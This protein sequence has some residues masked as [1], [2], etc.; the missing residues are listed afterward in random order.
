MIRPREDGEELD[1]AEDVEVDR[2]LV[3]LDGSSASEAILWPAARLAR[4]W[5]ATVTVL[6]IMPYPDEIASAY[7]PHTVQMNLAAL[8]GGKR[9]ATL[10]VDDIVEQLREQGVEADGKVEVDTSP[11]AGILRQLSVT[12]AGAVALATHGYGGIRRALLGSVADKVVRGAEGMALLVRP[13][14]D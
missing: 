13:T 5:E 2:I 4:T 11:S 7:L 10:Y 14:D 9:S 3:T 12:A 8:E 6:R 1:L